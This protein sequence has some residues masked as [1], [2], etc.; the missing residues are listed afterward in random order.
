[1]NCNT[2]LIAIAAVFSVCFIAFENANA[3]SSSRS[4]GGGGGG[5]SRSFGSG[6]G[7]GA[8]SGF[9][10]SSR[11]TNSQGGTSDL[12]QF[13]REQLSGQR[14]V[15]PEQQRKQ[16]LQQLASNP[17]SSQNK[18]QYSAAF[19]EAKFEYM[20]VLN[21]RIPAN[22]RKLNQVFLLRSKD[23]NR[24]THEINWPETFDQEPHAKLV[25]AIEKLISENKATKK[26]LGL[27]LQ[28]LSQ[29]LEQR[30]VA[31]SIAI[32]EYATAKRF[33]S[34]LANETEL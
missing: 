1:M 8:S 30:V 34:G 25:T 5:I 23:L 27:L 32:K 2:K 21:G 33:V 4:F 20:A 10:R 13:V 28:Q 15:S 24:K 11:S 26:D 22:G 3:Q 17:N 18:R 7:G 16:F 9:R 29:Q 31:K 14:Q 19:E 6:F 12:D